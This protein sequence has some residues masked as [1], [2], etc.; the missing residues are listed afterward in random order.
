MSGGAGLRFEDVRLHFATPEGGVLR[1]LDGVDFSVEEGEFVAVVG[2]SGCGK[3]TLL[4]LASGLIRPGQGRVLVGGRVVDGP[5]PRVGFM[6][7]RD[8]LMPWASAYQN[9]A[10]GLELGGTS[11]A[12]H[13][14]RI[15][16]LVA[17]VGLGG[18]EK[19]RPAQLSGGMRQRVALARLL[20]YDPDLYLLDEPFGALDAQTK[21]QMGRELLRIWAAARRRTVL[22]VTH[23]IEEAVALADRV[24]V[25]SARPARVAADHVVPLARPR[26]VRAIRTEEAYTA[27]CAAIWRDVLG[28]EAY[29]S[30]DVPVG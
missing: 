7:Q 6:F 19:S 26:A 2:P 30:E 21:M 9:I 3:S 17:L 15:A 12:R 1:V 13:A 28:A 4:R 25:L 5:P 23:D 11:K 16:E 14:A 24:V 18:F 27:T 22:F 8:T 20:A 10:M 29:S